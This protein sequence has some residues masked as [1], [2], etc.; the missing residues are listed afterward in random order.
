MQKN[1]INL[2]SPMLY[3]VKNEVIIQVNISIMVV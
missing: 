3:V 1:E 2:T